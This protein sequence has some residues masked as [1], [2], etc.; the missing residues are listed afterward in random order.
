MSITIENAE[1][2][3]ILADLAAR[4]RRP[5]SDLLLD[6]LRR[7]RMRVE[8]DRDRRIAEGLAADEDMRR[9]L[10]G[11]PLLDPRP[12]EEVLAYDAHGLP[13]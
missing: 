2:E 9:R 10:R 7:E 1:A 6:L 11:A 4:T 13:V 12:V 5:T 8:E 3:A